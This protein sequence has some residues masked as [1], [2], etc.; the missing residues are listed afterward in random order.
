MCNM[1]ILI[2]IHDTDM[3]K[4]FQYSSG[5]P[6]TNLFSVDRAYSEY[7]RLKEMSGKIKVF[8]DTDYN[9]LKITYNRGG[10]DKQLRHDL[11]SEIK[12]K[13]DCDE[14]I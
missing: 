12:T 1:Q 11:E 9:E 13:F 3:D 7:N 14:P 10:A 4:I 8:N 5:S 6:D 2:L